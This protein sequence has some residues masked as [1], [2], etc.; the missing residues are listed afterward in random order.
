[1][2][3]FS[4]TLLLVLTFSLLVAVTTRANAQG[5]MSATISPPVVAL[6]Y[7]VEF[8]E[9]FTSL[10]PSMVTI[11]DTNSSG[12]ESKVNTAMQRLVPGVHVDPS[13]FRFQGIITRAN[14]SSN[15]WD[16]NE[17]LT[18]NVIGASSGLAGITHY[19]LGFLS[20]NI[21]DSLAFG[22]LEFNR[23]GQS[24]IVQPLDSQRS[25]TRYYL[26]QALIRG[27]PYSNTVIPESAT[28]KFS[29]LDFSWVP[30]VSSWTHIYHPFDSSSVWTLSPGTDS[31]G[32]PF[33]VT[34]GIPSPEGTLLTSLTAFVNP[35]LVITS[36]ARSWSDSST[37]SYNLTTIAPSLMA[38]TLASIVAVVTGT[39]FSERRISRPVPQSRKRRR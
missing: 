1:M 27:G 12:F 18:G 37:I 10:S 26:D 39:Y 22:G 34:A 21:S 28:T 25:G 29:L 6:S 31:T 14:P 32:L 8:R 36:P 20:M 4:V 24:Y 35:R 7:S 23:V 9:N 19:D 3:L 5:M 15:M 16:I 33:N 38:L 11:D 13:S 2:K 17:N 30:K